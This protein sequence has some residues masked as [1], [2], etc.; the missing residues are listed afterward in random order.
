[1]VYLYPF[2][3]DTFGEQRLSVWH[4]LLLQLAFLQGWPIKRA[5]TVMNYFESANDKGVKFFYN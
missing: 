5:Y 1:M 4:I 2:I 3:T